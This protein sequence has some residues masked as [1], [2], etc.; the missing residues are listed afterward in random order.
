MLDLNKHLKERYFN[1][2]LYTGGVFIDN[3]RKIVT[4]MLYNL[5]GELVG[6][7]AYNPLKGKQRGQKASMFEQRYFNYVTNEGRGKKL[8]VW[9][10]ETFKPLDH[11]V[12][13]LCEG[14]F[15]ACKLHNVGLPA[16]AVLCNDPKHLRNWL[17]TINVKTVAICDGDKAGEALRDTADEF[18]LL[19]DGKDLGD[20]NMLEVRTL[21]KKDN[22]YISRW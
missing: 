19:P 22:N 2:Q 7:Q 18:I 21:L 10:L 4:F 3:E 20:M 1:A 15:D 5:T 17:G 9:G 12:L 11:K 14:V 6:Y 16:I 8:A 13:F